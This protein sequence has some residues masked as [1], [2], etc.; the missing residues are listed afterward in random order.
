M[1]SVSALHLVQ[2]WLAVESFKAQR[3]KT[4]LL[5]E[6]VNHLDSEH[7][8]RPSVASTPMETNCGIAGSPVGDSRAAPRQGEADVEAGATRHRILRRRDTENH[9]YCNCGIG[10]HTPPLTY[11]HVHGTGVTLLPRKHASMEAL[12]LNLGSGVELLNGRTLH[13]DNG[14]PSPKLKALDMLLPS[15]N[16]TLPSKGLTP[17]ELGMT[18]DSLLP[19]NSTPVSEFRLKDLTPNHTREHHST[20]LTL[21]TDVMEMYSK[22]L[23]LN[24]TKP[25]G[26]T[27][28]IRQR[29]EVRICPE[30]GTINHSCFEEPQDFVYKVMEKRYYPG[31]LHSSYL[32]KYQLDYIGSGALS[33][34]DF[35]LGENALSFFIEFMEQECASSLLQ[36]W[37]TAENFYNQLSS[38]EHVAD[39]EVDMSDAISIYTRYFSLQEVSR[40]NM[41]DSVRLDVENRICDEHGPRADSY[42]RPQLVAFHTMNEVYFPMFMDSS[43]YLRFLNELVQMLDKEYDDDSGNAKMGYDKPSSET[44]LKKLSHNITGKDLDDPNSLW[45]RPTFLFRLGFVNEFGEYVS[46]IDPIHIKSSKKGADHSWT[47]SARLLRKHR[48]EEDLAMKIA[49]NIIKEVMNSQGQLHSSDD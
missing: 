43:I 17:D 3:P 18:P 41:E 20:N 33:L 27:D 45:E 19:G 47:V 34:V 37:L 12:P 16:P 21:E 39:I 10:V 44:V 8:N 40:L 13:N 32:C 30:D 49:R 46:E 35:L 22:Y 26:M 42:L 14:S 31:F 2:F 28:E 5:G 11:S 15:M 7:L 24:A 25:V 4:P 38:P 23:A 6:K 48:K 1:E 29:V 9:K 36:F